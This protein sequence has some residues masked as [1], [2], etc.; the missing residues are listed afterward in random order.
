MS[1]ARGM[2]EKH[3]GDGLGRVDY[4]LA[5]GGDFV[6]RHSEAYDVW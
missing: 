3:A 4:A 1:F 6:V 2:V 5:N